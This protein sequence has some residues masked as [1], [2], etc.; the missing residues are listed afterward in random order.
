[1]THFRMRRATPA[2]RDTLVAFNADVLR[3]QD[4]PEL[5]DRVASWTRD[6]LDGRHP[7][8][9][10]GDFS[11][12]EDTRSG[13]IASSLCL[14]AQTWS[15]GGMSLRVGQPELVGTHPDYRG[16]GL[17]RRQL[18]ILHQWSAAR[19]QQLQAIDGIPGFYQ[20]FGYQMAL[21]LRGEWSVDVATAASQAT[22]DTRYRVRPA[23][24]A[25]VAFIADTGERSRT[26]YLMSACRDAALW[27]YELLGRSARNQW[28]V[29]LAIVE[30]GD[31]SPVG[32]L[33]HLPRLQGTV[34]TLI[35]YELLP[36]ASWEVV[37]P[38]VLRYLRAT[39][40]A[41]AEA[42]ATR[43]ERIGLCLGSDHPAYAAIAHLAPR[44][45][46]AYAW[47]LRVPDLPGFLRH[48]APVLE[49]RLA[50]SDC[51]RH[52]GD[53]RVSFYR[54]GVRLLFKDG[55]L[56]EVSSWRVPLGLKGIE[57]GV[58]STAG[59]ADASFP[60]PTFLQLLFGYR[61]LDELQYAFPDC[62]VRTEQ[63]R[64]LL[65]ALFPKQPSNVWPV[66]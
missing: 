50:H 14:I 58:P 7:H 2:D 12:V 24:A 41:Y 65:G 16:Q 37:T 4:S 54:D 61:S 20:Q 62:L 13:G 8:V 66:L 39:G 56:A 22:G 3:Y 30:A 1:M 27:R 26:R 10:A 9:G 49:R 28:R 17:V 45:D 6:L 64:A 32:F 38:G 48:V 11:L 34:V 31:G 55:R 25:D 40:E 63:A 46:G 33:V 5:D 36:P 29:A 52:T 23:G 43:C 42:N 15:Y 18:D 60:G 19:G 53:L 57:K 35:V 44:D 59:R 21:A 47:Q 51:A